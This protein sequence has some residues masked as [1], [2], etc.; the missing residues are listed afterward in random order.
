MESYQKFH[1]QNVVVCSS[2]E[3]SDIVCGTL[4]IKKNKCIYCNKIFNDRS[5]KYKHQKICKFKNKYNDTI[6]LELLKEENKKLELEIKL[7][8]N[9]N[10]IDDNSI[11]EQP[12][13]NQLINIIVDKT[14]L[15]KELKT[16]INNNNESNTD[17]KILGKPIIEFHK[18]ILNDVII[19][20]RTED[21]YINATQL[22]Q[23]G[24]KQ[25]NDWFRL[26][27]TKQ[28]ISVLEAETGTI[29]QLVDV[30]IGVNH[31][32]TWIHPDLAIQLAQWISP[33][34][35]LQVNGYEH[36]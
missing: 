15:L 1:N 3:V 27:T 21:N 12:I 9:N 8:T 29:S 20:S 26:N 28:L 19:V 31:S 35:S 22:C 23:A 14:K 24:N 10:E 30:K 17:N 34:F 18:L 32:G 33:I 25:F 5:N 36:Y 2:N 16:K 7:K 13:N 6:K 11:V 4:I